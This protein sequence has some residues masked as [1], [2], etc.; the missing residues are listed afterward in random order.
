MVLPDPDS[1]DEGKG[2]AGMEGER[3]RARR[4][5]AGR[6][7]AEDLR[8]VV[9]GEDGRRVAHAVASCAICST[10]EAR[11]RG[12]ELARVVV[13]RRAIDRLRVVDLDQLAFEHDAD[14]VAHL[15]HQREIVGDEEHREAEL[16]A[17]RLDALEDFALHDDI[18]RGGRLV[19]D[20]ELWD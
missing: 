9:E 2:A 7:T 5:D 18:E 12:P 19:H 1:P 20:E 11:H 13:L 4:I 8:D 14:A 17:Q 15:H 10:G 16:P 3:H 6:A